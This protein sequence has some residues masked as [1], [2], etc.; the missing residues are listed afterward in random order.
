MMDYIVLALGFVSCVLLITAVVQLASLRR[1][2]SENETLKRLE[3]KVH[4]LQTECLKSTLE[5]VK[6]ST[7]R[8]QLADLVEQQKLL[9]YQQQ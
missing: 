4:Q 6:T 8:F 9:K 2:R 3:G 7:F 1:N 5:K